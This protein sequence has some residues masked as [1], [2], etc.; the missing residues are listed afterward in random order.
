M[1]LCVS[2]CE[3]DCVCVPLCVRAHMCLDRPSLPPTKDFPGLEK[4]AAGPV[5]VLGLP[6]FLRL[7]GYLRPGLDL[8]PRTVPAHC[9]PG[10]PEPQGEPDPGMGALA[11]PTLILWLVGCSSGS[12]HL[13]RGLPLGV[14]FVAFCFSSGQR[15]W[16]GYWGQPKA[17]RKP[18]KYLLV[19]C[20]SLTA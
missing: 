14:D 16:T 8:S 1:C 10:P 12:P 17:S 19:T 2:V 13:D 7:R 5:L 6:G 3:C 18:R 4:V 11:P 15:V 9:D 20:P